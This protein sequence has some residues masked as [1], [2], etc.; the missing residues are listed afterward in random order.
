MTESKGH[1]E[2]LRVRARKTGETEGSANKRL[3]VYCPKQ[4]R[5]LA[6]E[7]CELCADYGGV[8]LDPTDR[9][10]FLICRRSGESAADDETL[11]GSADLPTL[12]EVTIPEPSGR[13][14]VAELMTRNVMCVEP[15]MS[16]ETLT[17]LLLEHGISGAP[18]IDEDRR[19]IGMISKSDLVRQHYE[20]EMGLELEDFTIESPETGFEYQLGP[21]FHAQ[22]I[23]RQT[24]GEVMMPLS[25]TVPETAS[26]ARAAGLMAF[27]G[28]HRVPVVDRKGRVVGILSTLDVLRW[29]AGQ[30]GYPGPGSGEE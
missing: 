17:T 3:M 26:L 20:S 21:G 18:V 12:P 1:S 16:L 27:E 25:F 8:S 10:S 28:I 11:W 19:P 15:S 4:H 14:R 22:R 13:V 6:L 7:E 24:V 2:R 5:M 29:L 9:D 23:T 30:S